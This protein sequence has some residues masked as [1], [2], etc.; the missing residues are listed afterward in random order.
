MFCLEMAFLFTS[1][2]DHKHVYPIYT[3]YILYFTEN[4]NPFSRR[5]VELAMKLICHEAVFT[6][7]A[8]NVFSSNFS[9]SL[10]VFKI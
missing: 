10:D 5:T 4:T 2:T 3:E 1:C 8:L 6:Y 9:S 7:I